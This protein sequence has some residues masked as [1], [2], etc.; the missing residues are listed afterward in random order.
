MAT[1]LSRSNC[2]V[3]VVVLL[4]GFTGCM[5][6]EIPVR[7]AFGHKTAELFEYVDVVAAA[8]GLFW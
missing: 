1:E 6:N 3:L 8:V 5:L 7:T 2:G 4:L